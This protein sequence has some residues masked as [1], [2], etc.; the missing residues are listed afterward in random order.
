LLVGAL[1]TVLDSNARVTP[2][3]ILLQV[4]GSQVS[5]VIASGATIQE[6]NKHWDWLIHNLL[7]SLSVFE[8]KEDAVSFVKG[9]VKGLIAEEVRGR[10]AAQEEDPGKFRDAL[11]KFEL[12]FSLPSSEK[13]VTYYSCCCWKGRVPR[14]GFLYL[15]VNHMAFYSFLLGK[16][17]MHGQG[18]EY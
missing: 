11:L 10:Q 8:N 12:H 15:S 18:W 14:Q 6:V 7:H 17:G 2:F 5:W 13:L 9:K 3:R 1:D 4:P 16:E